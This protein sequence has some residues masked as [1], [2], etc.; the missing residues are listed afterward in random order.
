MVRF[1]KRKRRRKS[2][3]ANLRKL[4]QNKSEEKENVG[5]K[6]KTFFKKMDNLRKK[7]SKTKN[8]LSRTCSKEGVAA[9]VALKTTGAE[10]QA[11]EQTGGA[12][13][14]MCNG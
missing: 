1:K 2:T 8:L 10:T 13:K 4:P 11:M 12:G 7:N 6:K 5:Y 9:A 14:Q 3:A